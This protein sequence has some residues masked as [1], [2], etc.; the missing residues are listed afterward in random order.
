MS[1]ED[2]KQLT[3]QKGNV[4]VRAFLREAIRDAGDIPDFSDV[5]RR[6]AGDLPCHVVMRVVTSHLAGMARRLYN[7]DLRKSFDG[8]AHPDEI[9][10]V[11]GKD[12]RL[13][14]A[15]ESDLQW[16]AKHRTQVS[17]AMLTRAAQVSA[18]TIEARAINHDAHEI[19]APEI[20]VRDVLI[21][22]RRARAVASIAQRLKELG[23]DGEKPI[24]WHAA[25]DEANELRGRFTEIVRDIRD[26]VSTLGPLLTV[27][28][29]LGGEDIK[30]RGKALVEDVLE[31]AYHARKIQAKG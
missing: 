27:N 23:G 5:A 15:T 30:I 3:G 24:A 31:A 6:V 1:N 2:G 26:T 18:T 12:V 25:L 10:S 7:S 22:E 14:S 4:S 9:V 20:L 17:N 28:W 19:P 11:R 8:S 13:G 16:L 21:A 29:E